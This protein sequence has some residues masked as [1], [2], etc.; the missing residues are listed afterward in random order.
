MPAFLAAVWIEASPPNDRTPRNTAADEVPILL[1]IGL[2]ETA[3][4]RV[5]EHEDSANEAP[6]RARRRTF[7][8]NVNG[9][10]VGMENRLLWF[11]YDIKELHTVQPKVHLYSLL[12]L[13]K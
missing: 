7:F 1:P 10:K 4:G 13:I 5:I 12:A 3:T 8:I 11:N 6:A 2:L 9:K